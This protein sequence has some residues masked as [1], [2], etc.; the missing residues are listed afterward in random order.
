MLPKMLPVGMHSQDF[1]YN[2][3]ELRQNC[4]AAL[5]SAFTENF[6]VAVSVGTAHH[7]KAP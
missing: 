2:M 3:P 1:K 6:R 5:M 4:N 7:Q